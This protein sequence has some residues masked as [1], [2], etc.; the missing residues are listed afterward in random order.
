MVVDAVE[1]I[2]SFAENDKVQLPPMLYGEDGST[3]SADISEAVEVVDTNGVKR[4]MLILNACWLFL[5]T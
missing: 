1:S 4:S 2:V 3:L 5:S